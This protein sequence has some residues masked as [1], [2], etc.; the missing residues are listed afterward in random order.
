MG[1]MTARE[2]VDYTP[3]E[4]LQCVI[5]CTKEP[6]WRRHGRQI[7]FVL[8][9]LQLST[10][11]SRKEKQMYPGSSY[12]RKGGN[13]LGEETMSVPEGAC[14]LPPTRDNTEPTGLLDMTSGTEAT[15]RQ[16][17]TFGWKTHP[18][19]PSWST[20]LSFFL[21]G[22]KQRR[23]HPHGNRTSPPGHGEHN[24]SHVCIK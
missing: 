20:V 7:H 10:R 15:Q 2:T 9:A 24:S 16:L 12:Y 17:I 3:L 19:D 5:Y 6:I 18:A 23:K 1:V 13:S 11:E 21:K 4:T 22:K 8:A 14:P